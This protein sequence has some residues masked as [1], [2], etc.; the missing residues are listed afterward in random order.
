MMRDAS[1]RSVLRGAALTT[2]GALAGSPFLVLSS[3]RAQSTAA[4]GVNGVKALVFDV[5]GTVVD[6]RG[7]VAR[8]AE[9][10]LKPRGYKLDWIAFAD[11]W[12][13]LYQPAM[14]GVRSGQQ[15]FVKL[16]VLH[17]RMLEQIR[18]RFGLEKLDETVLQELTLVWHRLDAWKDVAAGFARLHRRYVIAP[19]SNGNIAL[20]VDI[21]RRNNL[22]WDAILGSEIARDYKPKSR[23]YLSA[24]EAF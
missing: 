9:N 20:M 19:C 22:P 16:D 7:G 4:T 8:E 23:V 2:A 1:R 12:R 18:P 3:A 24:A 15:P 17:R 5:F 14:E 11:A 6:W 13:A 21:G 10:I